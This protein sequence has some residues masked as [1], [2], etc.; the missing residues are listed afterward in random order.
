MR[1]K[2]ATRIT[3]RNAA[4]KP[5]TNNYIDQSRF[6][7]GEQQELKN[8]NNEVKD[9]EMTGGPTPGPTA[10]PPGQQGVDV[11]RGTDQPLRPVEDGLA[12][13]P[14]VGPQESAMESTEQL[15]QQFYDL[16]GDPLLA[17]ILKG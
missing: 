16:T 1:M 5:P 2:M 6:V 7:Y 4:V 14:G 3:K 8:L 17:N 11:F 15:L 12:F 9:L 10:P 13:G